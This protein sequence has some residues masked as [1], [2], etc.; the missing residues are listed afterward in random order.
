MIISL[1]NIESLAEELGYKCEDLKKLEKNEYMMSTKDIKIKRLGWDCWLS[2]EKKKSE[3][4]V[5]IPWKIERDNKRRQVW[6][7]FMNCCN[8]ALRYGEERTEAIAR[9]I[10]ESMMVEIVS[11]HKFIS[12]QIKKTTTPL[13]EENG[14]TKTLDKIADYILFSKFDNKEQEEEHIKLKKEIAQLE[15]KKKTEKNKNKLFDAKHKKKDTPYMKVKRLKSLPPQYLVLNTEDDESQVVKPDYVVNY[16]RVDRQMEKG[17]F[18]ES[19]E[20]FWERFSP[21]KPNEIPFYDKEP[22]NYKE[23]AYST[24]KQYI[25]EIQ[26][27][28]DKPFSPNRAKVISN[29]KGEMRDALKVLRKVIH[30]QP[31][32]SIDEVIPDDAWNCLSLRDAEVYSVLLYNYSELYEKY[33]PKVNTNMWALLRTFEDLAEKTSWSKEEAHIVDLMLN[34]GVTKLEEIQE[35]L[36]ED[37]K[38]EYE[39]YQLSRIINKQL[40]K[41][42]VE[43]HEKQL[44]DWIWIHRRKG[45]YK[46]CN[47]CGEVKLAVDNRYFMKNSSGYLGLR[48]VCKSCEKS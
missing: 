14:F 3:P 44:E 46:T 35:A 11:D 45:K 36:R 18:D 19:M 5:L 25:A 37:Y 4:V 27:L 29:L 30:F 23:L 43:T 42:L 41:I 28:E 17:K 8:Y 2:F 13:S 9:G 26:Q 48:S 32:I 7:Q 47:S 24:M 1:E 39:K 12:Q 15:S 10:D 6:R 40:P 33:K 20:A 38:L 31:S 21:S 16:T 22:V 34:S